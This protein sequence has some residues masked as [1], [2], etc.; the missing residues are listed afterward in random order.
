MLFVIWFILLKQLFEQYSIRL[1]DTQYIS[2]QISKVNVNLHYTESETVELRLKLKSNPAD[3]RSAFHTKAE[4][5]RSATD[6][7]H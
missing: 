3:V 7:G 1:L 4:I 2:F 6:F 5:Y